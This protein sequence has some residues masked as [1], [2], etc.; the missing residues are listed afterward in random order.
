MVAVS[1]R[2]SGD[3]ALSG[4]LQFSAGT[5]AWDLIDDDPDSASNTDYVFTV[6]VDADISWIALTPAS[7][8]TLFAAMTSAVINYRYATTSYAGDSWGMFWQVF[9]ADKTTA[10]TTEV[11]DTGTG[12]VSPTTTSGAAI[13]AAGLAASQ[14][15]W[16]SALLRIRSTFNQ[17]MGPDNGEN[18]YHAVEINVNYDQAIAKTDF[19]SRL[20]SST[21]RTITAAL[22]Q[23]QWGKYLVPQIPWN[24][25]V[26]RSYGMIVESTGNGVAF[27]PD[28]RFVACA[29]ATSPFISVFDRSGSTFT[30]VSALTA[31]EGIGNGCA[32]S[33]DG[34]FLAV[35][36]TSSPNITVYERTAGA[37]AKVTALTAPEGTGNGCA[38]SRDGRFLALAHNVSPFITVYQRSGAT[39][40]TF[41]KVSALTAPEGTGNGCAFS[42]DGRF[43]AVAHSTSPFITVYQRSGTTF[44]KVS[45]L[46]ATESTGNGCVFTPDGRFLAVA[47]GTS[48]FITVYGRSGTTFTKVTALTAP[49]GIGRGCAFTPDGRFLAVTHD[50]TPFITVY[51][52][53]GTAFAK[54]AAPGFLPAGDGRSCAFSPDGRFLA[55]GHDT[56]PFIMLYETSGL[57]PRE[58][59]LWMNDPGER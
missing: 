28:G 2:P 33:S 8:F 18:R 40:T 48:P 50:T 59:Y 3:D 16:E 5:T 24:T 56:T 17:D 41:T 42:P 14:E 10:Y 37:F 30:K 13:N 43:L 12:N 47:H 34:R 55:V 23:D 52:R 36:H 31:P 25:P 26:R 9:A 46:T 19:P 45:A 20:N 15:D 6:R 11:G 53:S 22:A 4:N 1:L 35:A 32:W 38:F 49:E 57:N 54:R 51:G 58:G 44:T 21:A 7:V 29:H 27:S 39:G